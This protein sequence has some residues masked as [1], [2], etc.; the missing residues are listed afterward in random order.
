MQGRRKIKN[1]GGG[2]APPPPANRAYA[3]YL[4]VSEILKLSKL[5]A[6]E[7]IELALGHLMISVVTVQLDQQ[8]CCKFLLPTIN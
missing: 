3:T 7:K 2:R 6:L 1:C 5:H 4:S 8:L